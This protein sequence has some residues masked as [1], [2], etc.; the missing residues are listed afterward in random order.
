MTCG[1]FGHKNV[2]KQCSALLCYFYESKVN[3]VHPRRGHEGPEGEKRYSSTLSLTLA[4]DEV[5]G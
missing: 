3:K 5:G 1:V 2:R 4:L